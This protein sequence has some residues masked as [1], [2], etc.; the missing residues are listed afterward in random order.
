MAFSHEVNHVISQQHGGA[1][2]V[3]N[4]AYACMICNRF[5]GANLSSVDLSGAVV[6]LFIRGW[7]DGRS[8][9][10]WRA[11]WCSH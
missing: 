2:A 9:F 11:L 4:L 8:I 6:R 1:T 3:D 7:I 10:D 5:K